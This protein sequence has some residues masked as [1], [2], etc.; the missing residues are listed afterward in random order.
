MK[1][2]NRIATAVATTA[3]AVACTALSAN[4]GEN[5]LRDDFVPDNIGGVLG[6]SAGGDSNVRITVMPLE[7][8]KPGDP[9]AVR[10]VGK[11]L[12][13]CASDYKFHTMLRLPLKRGEK[14]RLSAQVRTH[15]LG[16]D[17]PALR[18]IIADGP[19]QKGQGFERLPGDTHGKWLDL[20]WEGELKLPSVKGDYT[21]VLYACS[22]S[23]GFPDD[24]WVDLRAPRLEG[25]VDSSYDKSKLMT[26]HSFPL[27]VT[28]VDP[29]LSEMRSAGAEMLFYCSAASDEFGR[30]ERKLLRATAADRTVTVPFASDGRAKAVFG[31]MAPGKINLRAEL[32]GADTGKVYV[33]N[34]YRAYVRDDIVGATPMK[35]LNNFVSEMIRRPYAAGDIEFTL[36]KDT[37]MYVALSDK[38]AKV[39]ASFDGKPAKFFL[40]AGRQELMHRLL[41]GRHVLSLKGEAKG[42][43]IVRSV[44]S[45]YRGALHKAARMNPNFTDYCYGEEY[46]K[47]FGLFG[48][49]NATSV[50]DSPSLPPATYRLI[51]MMQERGVQV[52]HSYGMGQYDSRRSVFEDYLAYVTNQPSYIAGQHGQFDENC[53]SLGQG[54]RSKANS[55]EVWW[56]AYAQERQIDIF[57]ND[58]AHAVHNYPHLDIPELSAYINSGD[59][60]SMM[61]AEV[62]YRSPETQADFDGI[63]NFAKR[64]VATMGALVPAAPSRFFY[65]FNGWMMIGG[66]TSWY[67]TGTDMRAFNAE[68]LRI[69]ATDPDFADMGG[70]ALSTP[71]CYEDFHRFFCAMLRYY[72]I[73]GGTDS[74]AAK[75]GMQVWPRHILNGDFIEGFSGWT[76]HAA[77]PG[78][79]APGHRGDVGNKWQGR[80]YPA[81]YKIPPAKRPGSDFAVFTQSAKGPNVLRRKITGL[82]PGRVYQL[83]CAVSDLATMNKGMDSLEY[84][85]TKPVNIPYMGIKIE[86]AEEIP[87]LRHIYDDIG[88]YGK[89]CV[90]PHRVVFRAR[91]SE[92]EAVFSD[93]TEA[94]SPAVSIGQKTMLNYIGVYPYFY[95]GEEQLELLKRFTQQAKDMKKKR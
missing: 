75:N 15:G 45:I 33:S 92:A 54:A 64:Q 47:A 69:F 89:L 11:R 48:G 80:Q 52:N 17:M 55:T 77:E 84:R 10:I 43:L 91:T 81:G 25:P 46:Y 6:W 21:C 4:A 58:G 68:M 49:I 9:T 61:L 14:Y 94:N 85:K 86:G 13:A 39:E 78:S 34:D 26:L 83:T 63:V 38:D 7:P 28:P 8:E 67:S 29:L 35:R 93:W 79:L 90:F 65:L 12:G 57:F 5:L 88:K 87:E 62:Y 23:A 3:L 82:E 19:W 56:H 32:V 16:N 24:A 20:S 66:W 1:S 41:R 51:D 50:H 27:R 73:D 42:E 76:A 72:C 36:A 18:F 70:A 30:G 31:P 22:S 59:G 60:H 37:C 95:E 2:R 44:K 71:A 53:I 40:E 74:F